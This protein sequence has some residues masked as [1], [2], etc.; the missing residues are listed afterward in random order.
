MTAT[1]TIAAPETPA[2]PR[3]SER[4][5]QFDLL[6][7][8]FAVLVLLSHAPELTDGNRS[9]E[10]LS[11]LTR[12]Q[13][14]F[15]ELAVAGFFLLSGFLIVQSWQHAP[16]LTDFLRKRVLRI[17]PGY[18][19]AALLSTLV[20]GIVAPGI[21]H[22]FLH[23]GKPFIKSMI[24]LDTLYTPLVYPGEKVQ[25][26]VNGSLW[27]ISY[28]FRC[29]LLVAV[30][31]VLLLLRR[32]IYWIAATVLLLI[33]TIVPAV[34]A[35]LQWHRG[36]FLTGE[37][38]NDF[39]LIPIFFIGGCFFLLRDR[40]PYRPS[41]AAAALLAPVLADLYLPTFF[42]LAVYIFGGYLLFYLGRI[43]LHALDWMRRVPDVS[44]G[45]Y[46]Y[47]WPVQCLWIWFFHGSP[48][49]NFAASTILCFGLGWLSWH[50]VERPML[51][52][53]RRSTAP[54]PVA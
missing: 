47:G 38:K 51:K 15:G 34:E 53:K 8:I 5:H 54:L 32:P 50:F 11:R 36:L 52:F 49:I 21:P 35:H 29:Y 16:V 42:P 27:T 14:S 3:R 43:P 4:N 6:R 25:P 26:P 48:W 18:V 9:R 44:Y 40:I 22:F 12:S 46:L 7:I 19:V 28:E 33:P 23:L 20:V 10:L 1:P 13:M 41:L 31:G 30:M 39:R 24:G 17:V 45:I 37:P 2:V